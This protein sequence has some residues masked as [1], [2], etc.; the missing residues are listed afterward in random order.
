MM[1]RLV[2]ILAITR[3]DPAKVGGCPVKQIVQRSFE[4]KLGHGSG[5]PPL[6][7]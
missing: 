6:R 2:P 3:F 7:K 1:L 4:F 5:L